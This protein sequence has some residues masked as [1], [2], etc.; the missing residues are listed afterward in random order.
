MHKFMQTRWL[1]VHSSSV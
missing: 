1:R